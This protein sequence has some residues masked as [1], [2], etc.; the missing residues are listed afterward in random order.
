MNASNPHGNTAA[1]LFERMRGEAVTQVLKKDLPA[2]QQE[3][4][5]P[6]EAGTKAYE[7]R[8]HN[9]YA[10]QLSHVRSAQIPAPALTG[11]FASSTLLAADRE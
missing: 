9:A 3:A 4:E 2:T 11:S 1:P 7:A 8:I 6:R 10:E 5:P